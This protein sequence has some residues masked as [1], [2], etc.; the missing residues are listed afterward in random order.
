MG[1]GVMWAL[2]LL[3]KNTEK[4]RTQEEVLEMIQNPIPQMNNNPRA[5]KIG[6]YL[7]I[8]IFVLSTVLGFMPVE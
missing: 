2:S 4:P 7:A 3:L 1:V 5:L 6:V 8:L